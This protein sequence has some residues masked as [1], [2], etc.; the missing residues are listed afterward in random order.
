MRQFGFLLFYFVQLQLP[1][2]INYIIYLQYRLFI[3]SAAVDLLILCNTA[4]IVPL[5]CCHNCVFTSG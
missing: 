5:Y 1:L 3:V 2:K 4:Q